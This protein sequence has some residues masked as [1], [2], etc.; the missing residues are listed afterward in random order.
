MQLKISIASFM[1][2]LMLLSVYVDLG[3][4]ASDTAT[5]TFSFTATDQTTGRTW[6]IKVSQIT[7]FQ[8]S[9]YEHMHDALDNTDYMC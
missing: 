1:R 7:C 2:N 6:E 9:Q 4:V 8:K 5:L 3:S